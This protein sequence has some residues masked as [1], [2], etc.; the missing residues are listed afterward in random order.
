MDM[1]RDVE[2]GKKAVCMSWRQAISKGREEESLC[3]IEVSENP[4]LL[5]AVWLLP[6]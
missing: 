3:P 6:T 1:E 5:L 4:S 2:G